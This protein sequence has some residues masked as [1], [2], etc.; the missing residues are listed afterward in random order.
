MFA[1]LSFANEIEP[2]DG[3]NFFRYNENYFI[4]GKEETK[5]QLS[6]KMQVLSESNL[7]LAYTQ[8][9]FWDIGNGQSHF[10]DVNYNPEVFYRWPVESFGLTEIDYCPL[11]HKSDGQNEAHARAWNRTY[12][13][14]R[15]D[16]LLRNQNV[17]VETKF[18]YIYSY[19]DTNPEIF[20]KLGFI[21]MSAS[22]ENLLSALFGK[23]ELNI[24][25]VPGGV[26]SIQ[27]NEGHQ[28]INFKI[29]LQ[30]PKLN[31]SIYFQVYNGTDESLLRYNQ[32]ATSYRVGLAL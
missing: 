18:F 7:Y 30:I 10:S 12:V 11:E 16:F 31:P 5:I 1:S 9:M 2:K 3:L 29:K 6:F 26:W 32:T 14:L 20:R 19:D 27:Q 25:I 17:H 13:N 15:N 8:V 28:E 24:K 23:D 4:T 21:E 22:F